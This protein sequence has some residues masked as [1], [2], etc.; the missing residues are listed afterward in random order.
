M[1]REKEREMVASSND[2]R[3]MPLYNKGLLEGPHDIPHNQQQLPSH[4][5]ILIFPF[6]PFTPQQSNRNKPFFLLPLSFTPSRNDFQSNLI[7]F[8]EKNHENSRYRRVERG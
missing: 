4:L 3:V 1:E 6:H 2:S 7:M 8:S 5:A